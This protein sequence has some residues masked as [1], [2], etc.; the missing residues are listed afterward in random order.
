MYVDET[1]NIISGRDGE[2]K[3]SFIEVLNLTLYISLG[4]PIKTLKKTLKLKYHQWNWKV[5]KIK[6]IE[7]WKIKK[8]Y[9][10]HPKFKTSS[11][12]RIIIK[13]EHRAITLIKQTWL[14]SNIDR[15]KVLKK[16]RMILKKMSNIVSPKKKKKIKNMENVRK[17][18]FVKLLTNKV[19]IT[20]LVSETSYYIAKSFCENVLAIKMKRT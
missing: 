7:N 20:Y 14:K 15:N 17:H 13:K 3:W 4:C 8:L 2:D 5:W 1:T 18:N 11:K 6:N 12:S 19:E 9:Y 16:K 10:P